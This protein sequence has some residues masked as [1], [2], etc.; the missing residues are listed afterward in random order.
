MGRVRRALKTANRILGTHITKRGAMKWA[1][2]QSEILEVPDTQR[3]FFPPGYTVFDPL[4]RTVTFR[5][6]PKGKG[7]GKRIRNSLRPSVDSAIKW[8]KKHPGKIYV[9]R[10]G[11]VVSATKLRDGTVEVFVN[12]KTGEMEEAIR[13]FGPYAYKGRTEAFVELVHRP[14][15]KLG[16]VALAAEGRQAVKSLTGW[17]AEK[18]A[19]GRSPHGKARPVVVVSKPGREEVWEWGGSFRRARRLGNRGEG[20]PRRKD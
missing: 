16:A 10:D 15:S 8:A 5:R 7:V 17:T 20:K 19:S 18:V 11:T 9:T 12:K 3:S 4:T 1:N 2:E 6:E 13:P 14:I